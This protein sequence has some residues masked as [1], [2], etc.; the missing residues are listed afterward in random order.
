MDITVVA[1]LVTLIIDVIAKVR[2]TQADNKNTTAVAEVVTQMK[3]LAERL[4]VANQ[5][6]NRR[7][8]MLEARVDRLEATRLSDSGDSWRH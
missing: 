1:L 5:A 2:Q 7:C 3:A 4:E 6:T 8:E